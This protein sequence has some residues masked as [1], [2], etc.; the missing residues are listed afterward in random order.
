MARDNKSIGKFILDGILP[1]PRGAPQIEVTFD[2]DANG[3]LSVS[4]KDNG[5]GKEQKIV[6]Q[7]SSG[8]SNEEV[9]SMVQEAQQYAEED[10]RKRAEAEIRNQSEQLTYTAEKLLAEHADKVPTDVKEEVEGK[11]TALRSAL[12]QND[13]SQMEATMNE[14]NASLQRLG[15]TVYGQSTQDQPEDGQGGTNEAP[16]GDQPADTVEGEYREV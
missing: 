3:I 7:P 11:I 13:I 5:T 1:A 2:I 8:L 4:A 9:E 15:E 14:L 10:K 12:E 16:E 6:I